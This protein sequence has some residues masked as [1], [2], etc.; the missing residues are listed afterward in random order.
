LLALLRKDVEQADKI[1]IALMMQHATICRTWI[2]AIRHIIFELKKECEN[3]NILQGEQLPLLS[4]E[5][6][7][8]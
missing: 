8:K 1:H 7:E 5:S 3:L 4:I 6:R 2:P